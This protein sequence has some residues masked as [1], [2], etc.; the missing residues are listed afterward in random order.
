MYYSELKM[1]EELLKHVFFLILKVPLIF[2]S[3]LQ[4]NK[5]NNDNNNTI[6]E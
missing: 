2:L 3:S 1:K 6:N 5:L 4:N